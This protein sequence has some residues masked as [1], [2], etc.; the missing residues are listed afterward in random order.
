MY[1]QVFFGKLY[2]ITAN[3]LKINRVVHSIIFQAGIHSPEYS[4]RVDRSVT[5]L[6]IIVEYVICF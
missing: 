4:D 3:I 1:A 6:F 2:V 5:F